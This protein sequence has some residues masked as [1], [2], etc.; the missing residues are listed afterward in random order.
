MKNSEHPAFRF[1]RGQ[2]D[3]DG[4]CLLYALFNARQAL[5]RT[6]LTHDAWKSAIKGLQDANAFLDSTRGSVETD[7]DA[8][9]ERMLAET[10]INKLAPEVKLQVRTLK[11]MK[12]GSLG[13]MRPDQN[14]VIVCSNPQ[15]WFC[16]VESNDINAFI[17]CSWVWQRELNTYSER[18]SPE[19]DR[20]FNEVL[21][22]DDLDFFKARA[23]IVCLS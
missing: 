20:V 5:T 4:A 21:T 8:E 16:I 15:H 19:L 2:G 10:F 14:S 23:L 18:I 9:A 1:I 11:N 6:R 13:K 17:A 12:N 22:L 7:G 3:L